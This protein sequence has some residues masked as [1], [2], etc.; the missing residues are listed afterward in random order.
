[1]FEAV[2]EA[3]MYYEKKV[4]RVPSTALL[5]EQLLQRLFENFLKLLRINLNFRFLE[6]L[7]RK[8]RHEVFDAFEDSETNRH[9]RQ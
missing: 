7:L 2:F 8:P 6:V 5:R 3:D 1:M 9:G 4:L